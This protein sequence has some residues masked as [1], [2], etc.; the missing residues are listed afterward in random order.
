MGAVTGPA[1]TAPVES[2]SA[3]ELAYATKTPP[4]VETALHDVA[5]LPGALATSAGSSVSVP[6]V[7]RSA[8]FTV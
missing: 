3:R 6:P 1:T 4:S 5:P 7:D 2:T 8:A